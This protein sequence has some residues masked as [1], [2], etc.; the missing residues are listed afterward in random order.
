MKLCNLL[1]NIVWVGTVIYG[2]DT[3]PAV[4]IFLGITDNS[5]IVH[6]NSNKFNLTAVGCVWEGTKIRPG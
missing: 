3:T 5:G 1:I 4:E 2:Q 6:S